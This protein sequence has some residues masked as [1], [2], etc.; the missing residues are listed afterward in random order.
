MGRVVRLEDLLAQVDPAWESRIRQARDR[1]R[2][3]IAT[4]LNNATR[5]SMSRGG[6]RHTVVVRLMPGYP[7]RLQE[8]IINDWN[9]QAEHLIS[10]RSRLECFLHDTGV[11]LDR[12]RSLPTRAASKP[13]TRK[14]W[15]DAFLRSKGIAEHL[16]RF[17]VSKSVVKKILEVDADI[18]GTYGYADGS[19]Q[20]RLYWAVI[21]FV[22]TALGVDPIGLAMVV[23]TH[24]LAHAYTH[25]GFDADGRVWNDFF[26]SDRRVVEGQAQY[27]THLAL[28]QSA[29]GTDSPAIQTAYRVLTE[30]QPETYQ[31]H[32][33]WV[34]QWTPEAVRAAML[35]VRNGTPMDRDAFEAAVDRH[36]QRLH[37]EGLLFSEEQVSH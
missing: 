20:V 2:S 32:L 10:I 7:T 31:R 36:H 25:I 27:Y 15:I 14:Q 5:L 33:H 11:I 12:I 17:A 22:A 18:L 24:E 1:H 21:A 3:R 6:T 37:A 26:H 30:H 9:E 34:Q 16:L 19:G 13:E 35:E 29:I 28:E 23:L 8:L 4:A